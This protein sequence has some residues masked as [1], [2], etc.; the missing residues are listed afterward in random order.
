M[1][2]AMKA[3]AI[4]AVCWAPSSWAAPAETRPAAGKDYWVEPMKKVRARYT[5]QRGTVAQFGDS[6]TI[7]MAFFVPLQGEIRN[8]PKDLQAAHMWIRG[9]V[10][11]R[12][13]RAWKGAAYGNEGR[14]TTEWAVQNLDAWLKKLN[15][16]VA[17]VMWGTNDTYLG[18]HPPRYTDNLRTIVQKC[19]DNGTVP[20]L[21]TIP[22]KG[23]QAGN[24]KETEAV[25]GFVKAA[26]AVAKEKKVP[27]ID[28]Y[29]EMLSRQP[30]N[31]HK[32]LLGDNLHPSYPT[33]YQRDFSEVALKNSGYTLRNYLTLK[34]YYEVHRKVLSKVKS[35]RTTAM[36]STWKGQRYKGLP[37]VL[38]PEVSR[39]PKLDGKLDDAAWKKI[40]PLEFRLLDGDTRKPGFPTYAKLLSTQEALYVAI[41]CMDP[42][43]EKVFSKKRPRDDNVWEDD[44]VEVFLKAGPQPS[45]EYHQLIVNP[46][47]SFLDAF[48]RDNAAWQPKVKVATATGTDHWSVEIVSP[49]SELKLPADKAA[50]AGAWRLNLYR[51]RPGR[52][53]RFAEETA[54]S[55]T[56]DTSNHVPQKFAFAFFQAFGGKLPKAAKSGGK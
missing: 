52:A 38:V 1:K 7:T 14:T 9:Y 36:E 21:Y 43:P 29:A 17:L 28:F 16:E 37:A 30:E 12:C 25:L 56:E 26:R 45:M 20:I 47:G 22:P 4:V 39:P 5:G 34:T 3:A 44:S 54:L 51:A 10:Q 40:K 55:P 15:P 33:Q 11:G 6:I 18:P 24:P 50:L 32:K 2:A 53:G 19:L 27:L 48:A 42:E 23:S 41:R 46:D 35:A 8:L 31:F 13:W 49:F